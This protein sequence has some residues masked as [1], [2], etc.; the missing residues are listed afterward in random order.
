MTPSTATDPE[1][2]PSQEDRLAGRFLREAPRLPGA[3][4]LGLI[5]APVEPWPHQLRVVRETVARYPQGFLFCDEVGLGKTIEAGLALRQ[6]VLSGRVRRALLLVP[7]A[8]LRQWQEELHE[9]LAL[10]VPRLDGGRFLDVRGREVAGRDDPN[11]WNRHDLLLASTHGARLRRHRREL[12]GAEPWDLLLVDEAHHARRRHS[13]EGAGR[14]NRLMELLAGPAGNPSAVAGTALR[15]ESGLVGRSRCTYLL[16]ATPMQ[17]HPGEVRDL[18]ALVGVRAVEDDPA[19]S[20]AAF[21]SSAWR[22]TRRRLRMY[23]DQGLLDVPIPVRRPENVWVELDAEQRRVYRRIEDYL[24]RVYQRYE[25]RRPGL[26]FVVTVYRRRLTSSFAAIRSSLERRRDVLLGTAPQGELFDPSETPD[27]ELERPVDIG[28]SGDLFAAAGAGAKGEVEELETF[29]EALGSLGPE[30]KVE[31][32]LVD[33]EAIFRQR[34]RVLV[35]TQYVDTL[36]HLRERLRPLY[37][38]ACYSGRGGEVLRDGR[39]MP[40]GKEALKAAFGRG[41]VQVLLC[42]EAASEGL[43]LQTCGVLVNVDLPW[44]PMRV[45]QRIGRID[46]L[47]QVHGEVWIRNYFYADTVEA[48]VYRRLADRIDWFREVVGE[49]Q[50]ILHR[51]GDTLK[52][53]AMGPHL[54][55]RRKLRERVADL[56]RRLDESPEQGTPPEGEPPNAPTPAASPVGP[57]EIEAV[58]RRTP[59]ASFDPSPNGIDGVHL[60]RFGGDA[61]PVT[62]RPEVFDRYPYSVELLTYGQPLFH[63]L[64]DAL[65][66]PSV[67]STGDPEDGGPSLDRPVGIGLYR[68]RNPAPVSLFLRPRGDSAEIV[69]G[70]AELLGPGPGPWTPRQEAEASATFSRQRRR[71]LAGMTGVEAE[72]R[73]DAAVRLRGATAELLTEAACVDLARARNPGL[74][75]EPLDYGFGAGAAAA[76]ARHGPPL[77]DLVERATEPLPEVLVTDPRYLDRVGLAPEAMDRAWGEV[78]GRAARLVEAWQA[79]E[80]EVS[81]ARRDAQPVTAGMLERW[82]FPVGTPPKPAA[83][84]PD[85]LPANGVRPFVDAVPF[86][87][88]LGEAAGWFASALEDGGDPMGPARSRPEDVEWVVPGG[89][90]RVDR[91]TFASVVHGPALEPRIPDG[92]AVLFRLD[93]RPPRPGQIVLVHGVSDPETG[94]SYVVRVWG[95]AAGGPNDE[96]PRVRLEALAPGIP[97][98]EVGEDAEEARVLGVLLEVL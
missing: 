62:F 37:R 90:A 95:T 29:L 32:L 8:V 73:R 47:G 26:G 58:L 96:T 13:G 42:T 63:R 14:P 27:P 69:D 54:Q 79:L 23:R 48:E 89:R 78:T 33:L 86:Y 7:K 20:R 77:A 31:R 84:L 12:L 61:H 75:D 19:S 49:L 35:F 6:L 9:K 36:D 4:D 91:R 70:M 5:T 76:Q 65:D 67:P 16:T 85:R 44:N 71:V 38:V 59:G 97:A 18:L 22:H 30:P 1:S 24:S 25:A 51:V 98:V 45:E 52:D 88:D 11:P 82:Y 92:A 2:V 53:L 43:N 74:F 60:L 94:E 68:S 21:D 81:K 40:E 17:I 55:R 93:P 72:R 28:E 56:R 3:A 39:W 34:D 10:R 64:L 66:P 83:E 57:A 15:E 46:R 41:D 80:G 87:P 50:P